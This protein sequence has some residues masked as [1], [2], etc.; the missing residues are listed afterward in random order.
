MPLLFSSSMSAVAAAAATA[1]AALVGTDDGWEVSELS[2]SIPVEIELVL[3]EDSC[4]SP[5]SGA[6]TEF[7]VEQIGGGG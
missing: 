6:K 4:S 5:E 1:A 2:P 7:G 3:G